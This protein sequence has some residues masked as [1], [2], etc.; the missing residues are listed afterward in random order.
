M[1]EPWDSIYMKQSK[2]F[3]FWSFKTIILIRFCF[4]N[5]ING[6]QDDLNTNS[7]QERLSEPSQ[8][9]LL[10]L[11]VWP[12]L[13]IMPEINPAWPAWRYFVS[14]LSSRDRLWSRPG[15]QAGCWVVSVIVLNVWCQPCR[16]ERGFYFDWNKWYIEVCGGPNTGS[17]PETK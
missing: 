13:S 15:R 7:G 3:L 2:G 4:M 17:T 9:L 16:G 10:Q 6:N 8:V 14:S 1:S 11:V 12:T 5:S